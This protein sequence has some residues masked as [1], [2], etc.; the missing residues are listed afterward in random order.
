MP[1]LQGFLHKLDRSLAVF[2]GKDADSCQITGRLVRRGLPAP[3]AF[4][5]FASYGSASHPRIH[6]S[7]VSEGCRA[8]TA[9]VEKHFGSSVAQSA[10]TGVRTPGR[11][12]RRHDPTATMK[13]RWQPADRNKLRS[14]QS[15]LLHSSRYNRCIG[16][17]AA[18]TD[19]ILRHPVQRAA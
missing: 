9:Q 10:R 17:S 15:R 12:R 19:G 3:P 18:N 14:P 6:R 5:R 4:A 16:P 13:R 1:V 11:P 8:E 2:V 7:G